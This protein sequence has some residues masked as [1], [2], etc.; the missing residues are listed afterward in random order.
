MILNGESVINKILLFNGIVLSNRVVIFSILFLSL[1]K[2]SIR[3]VGSDN[4]FGSFV[5]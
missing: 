5:L 4:S 2:V 1:L 3:I